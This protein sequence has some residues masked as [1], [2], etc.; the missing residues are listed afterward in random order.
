MEK[1]NRILNSSYKK[2]QGQVQ[3][4]YGDYSQI[5]EVE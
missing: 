3:S 4:I 5:I 1:K 2:M